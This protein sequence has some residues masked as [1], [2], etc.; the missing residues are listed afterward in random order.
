MT[1]ELRLLASCLVLLAAPDIAREASAQQARIDITIDGVQACDFS[2]AAGAGTATVRVINSF[3]FQT[4]R[5]KAPTPC[6]LVFLSDTFPFLSIGDSQTGV[7]ITMP[8]CTNAP[9]DVMQI[10]FFATSPVL[11]CT[12]D[13]FPVDG[14]ADILLAD[15]DGYAMKGGSARSVYCGD[16]NAYIAPY[17]PNP[18]DGATDVPTNT[19][20]SFIGSA[21][22]I[23]LTERGPAYAYD[24]VACSTA[25]GTLCDNP[26]DPGMLK[27]NTTYYWATIYWCAGTCP[28]GEG[29][30]SDVWSF[31]TGDAPVA[32]EPTTWGKVKALYR[33]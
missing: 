2:R 12:W 4:I 27:P 29:A 11:G 20:L 7:S 30:V 31:T 22:V 25:F 3:P 1:R 13:V 15:C 17:R 28:E 16:V 18:P 6:G 26:F 19:L 8:L 23:G 32:A 21:N 14:D 33:D 24:D 10:N 5:F 9:V